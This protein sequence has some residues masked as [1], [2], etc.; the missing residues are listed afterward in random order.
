MSRETGPL[1]L[2]TKY[3]VVKHNK[4]IH[5]EEINKQILQVL[6]MDTLG[7]GKPQQEVASE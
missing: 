1:P 7:G 5:F 4:A 2:V 3:Q 6:Y